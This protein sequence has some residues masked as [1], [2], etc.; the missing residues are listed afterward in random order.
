MGLK[1]GKRNA[2]GRVHKYS[3]SDHPHSND[4]PEQ[5]LTKAT[6]G[7]PLTQG[8]HY[9]EFTLGEK[10]NKWKM[11]TEQKKKKSELPLS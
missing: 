9:W 10:L 1:G 4:S 6:A 3:A 8:I 11:L 7:T 2:G 5:G